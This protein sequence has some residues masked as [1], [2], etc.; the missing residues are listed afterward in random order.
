M[1]KVHELCGM[2]TFEAVVQDV[3]HSYAPEQHH[4]EKRR[5]Q[6]RTAQWLHHHSQ[7]C[8]P[9]FATAYAA[10]RYNVLSTELLTG[11]QSCA[12]GTVSALPQH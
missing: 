12:I 8:L 5:F 6:P 11:T 7:R 4:L 9:D 1:V 10:L 2:Q 3:L